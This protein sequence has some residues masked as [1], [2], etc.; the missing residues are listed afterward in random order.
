MYSS[1][2]NIDDLIKKF[3]NLNTEIVNT[4][5]AVSDDKKS[6]S[7]FD[8][9]CNKTS[10]T[11]SK[12]SLAFK[13][14]ATNMAI[15]VAVNLAV[16]A[17]V[18]I[19]DQF[20]TTVSEVEADLENTQ[21]TIASLK[22]QIEELEKIDANAL[23]QGQ[24]D[25]LENLKE[26]LAVEQQLE[27][28]EKRRLAREAVGNGN[29]AD[30]FDKDSFTNNY[31]GIV[32]DL[33]AYQNKMEDVLL[34]YDERDKRV[35]KIQNEIAN[36]KENGLTTDYIDKLE[37]KLT[38][39][40]EKRDKSREDIIKSQEDLITSK[41]DIQ[42]WIAKIQG[43]IDDGY[44][45]GSD[46]TKANKDLADLNTQL[47]F[48]NNEIDR[49]NK[50]LYGGDDSLESVLGEKTKYSIQNLMDY[51]FTE[52]ELEILATLKFD[53]NSSLK[54]L[55][56]VLDEAQKTV[57]DG[58]EE[59]DNLWGVPEM[60]TNLDKAKDK[61]STLDQIYSKL[62]DGD[63]KTNIG[64]EDFADINETFSDLSG[65]DEYILR[66]QEAG[67]NTEQVTAV[68]QDLISAYI[69]QSQ[70]L[71]NVTND[72]KD[73]VVSMLE[74]VGVANATKL[75]EE[76][77][78]VT[79]RAR[80][81]EED[82][83]RKNGEILIEQ[84]WDKIS[85]YLNE[86][87][88]SEVAKQE[89]AL[90][91]LEQ[92]DL[93]NNPLDLSS[94]ISEI[95]SIAKAAKVAKNELAKLQELEYAQK[96]AKSTNSS[97]WNDRFYELSKGIKNISSDI[98][99]VKIDFEPVEYAPQKSYGTATANALENAK[100]AKEEAK[101][102][103]D[104]FERRIEVLNQSISNLEAGMEN[105]IGAD[106][107]NTLLSA[108]IGVVDEEIRNY[109]DALSMYQEKADEALSKVDASLRDKLVNGAV[110]IQDFIG[111]NS[112][113]VV[114]A[115]NNYKKWA[116]KISD[117]SVKLEELK[118]QIRQLEL[119]KFNNIIEDFTNQ[120]DIYENSNDLI[121]KQISLLEEAGELV[122]QSYYTKQI[123]QSQKQLNILEAE[124]KRLVDQ[125]ND[126][127]TSG[128]IQQGTD[129]WLEMHK[130]LVD[131]EGKI[132]D[133]KKSVE[134]FNNELLD[135]NWKIFE[136]V[137]TEF[138]NI[139]T[140]LE[141]IVGL[142]DDFNDIKVSDGKGTWTNEAIATL[143]LYA[144]QYELARYQVAQYS[145]AIEKLKED[146]LAG[147]YSATEY[148]DKLAELSQGQWDA[149]NSAHSL[150]DAIVSLNETRINEE[151]EGIEKEVDAYK[152]LI[153]AQL[154]L[155]EETEKLNEKRKT[156][157]EKSKS[158]ADIEKK[159]ASMANDN[160]AATIAKRK[161]LEDELAKAKQDLADTEHDYSIESQ[162]DA[163]NK[164]YE[165]Y[166]KSKNDEIEA[167]KLNLENKE[168]LI[169]QSLET[170]K[171]NTDLI[172]QQ[173]A[174]IAQEHGVT[175]SNAVITPWTQGENAIASYGATLSTQSSAF[176][177]TL[178]GVENEVYNLQT[179]ANTASVAISNMFGQRAD[180]LNGEL[181][182]SY[183]SEDNLNTM[184]GIL[185][186]SLINT[187]EGGYNVSGITSAMG[188]IAS[189]ADSVASAANRAAN[190]LKEMLGAQA[191]KT[192]VETSIG[193]KGTTYNVK[194][195]YSGEV[196]RS[197]SN[198]NDAYAY[199]QKLND[200][201]QKKKTTVSAFAKGGIISNKDSGDLDFVA[202]SLGEDHTIV[203]QNG[204]AVI[205]KES[206]EKNPEVVN[207]L[208][209]GETVEPKKLTLSEKLGLVPY[210]SETMTKFT[211]YLEDNGYVKSFS[212]PMY[213]QNI[214]STQKMP[215]VVLR[216]QSN[217]T[218]HYDKMFEFN[219]D[220][221]NSEQL[222]GQMQNVAKK[223][224]TGMLDDINRDFRRRH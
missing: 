191:Q 101:S 29:W 55:R 218:L 48:V 77:L 143:G 5:K 144:Q 95:L 183:V 174:L 87:N 51:G 145:D 57:D 69:D 82:Y 78:I 140:E 79:T 114:E 27:E 23:T 214:S 28:I 118:S 60:I 16:K 58:L 67:S 121:S 167:L 129:E 165:D 76:A 115:M 205:S 113:D 75:V 203:V 119:Q 64:F 93:Q 147:K 197:F 185:H 169:S 201:N 19:W 212:V 192:S 62:F 6:L 111:G 83:L 116:D 151:I 124:K 181:V 15:M 65:I 180:A 153:D 34:L 163:L 162:K 188:E 222:L 54:Q 217:V 9:V 107:K 100:S 142:F 63:N 134:E 66:L 70:I 184:T 40:K 193:K 223:I 52:D 216:Q 199:W 141:N 94:N 59:P 71:E 131:V 146:Y 80:S 22:S 86:A 178:M 43:Y 137:Q 198:Y 12:L 25:K 89:I 213:N 148:M 175:V 38:K 155:I 36:A 85:A 160:T 171:Q 96:M 176:I 18:Y 45:V 187:L 20:D 138:G 152:E 136:R 105:V 177:G 90:L 33:S 106:A 122:G 156:L 2:K 224:T 26:Q 209:N 168:L 200:P 179:E 215:D 206:V 133:C 161:Q 103:F 7:D 74:K 21:S 202:D 190:A 170:V 17:A 158:V 189:S 157:A 8:A 47:R 99:T 108:Q 221:N 150:E 120:F 53:Q 81:I 102:T 173:I 154:E 41:A 68:M 37:N 130:S 219:G 182:A 3:P 91:K 92:L 128:K 73:L 61:L 208:V 109:T 88:A 126:S 49:N 50:L 132:I 4:A 97:Y 125:L 135:L 104:Y 159:L 166:E 164:Q 56:E 172:G 10:S 211:K 112:S 196:L 207:A 13:N 44:L 24:K 72:N 186:N 110:E 139:S 14:I 39:A 35:K 31:A 42:G 1:G 117:C 84:S 46:L 123:E 204:E 98:E 11:A 195:I 30:Y 210:Q 149:V 127:I 220:F 194:D 32:N